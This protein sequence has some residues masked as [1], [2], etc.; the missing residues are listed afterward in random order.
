MRQLTAFALVLALLSSGNLRAQVKM[1][2]SEFTDAKRLVSKS[3]RS[4]TS[5]DYPGHGSFRAE[6]EVR[7]K[8]DTTWRLS[9][10]GFATDTTRMSDASVVRFRT[11]G[12]SLTSRRVSS[13]TRS[14]DERVVEVKHVV[15]TRSDFQKLATAANVEATIGPF[16]FTLTQPQREDL[17][18][19]TRRVPLPSETT[20][21]ASE[22]SASEQ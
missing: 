4:L 8:R 11:D 12:D 20:P 3:L 16:Q 21:V 2:T 6:Y 17:R 19:I 1:E 7:P 10:F 15:L 13:S 14:L 18:R 22:D 5:T 9:L